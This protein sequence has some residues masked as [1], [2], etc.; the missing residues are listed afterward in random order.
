M[1]RSRRC[2]IMP[3]LGGTGELGLGVGSGSAASQQEQPCARLFTRALSGGTGWDGATLI[4]RLLFYAESF[5][6]TLVDS[7]AIWASATATF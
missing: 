4:E 3:R 7:E 6:H 5:E 2:T 1:R